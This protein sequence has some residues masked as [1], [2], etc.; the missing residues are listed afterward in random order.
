MSKKDIIRNIRSFAI[1]LLIH[2]IKQ[3][4]ENRTT[5]SWDTSIRNSVRDIQ[6]LNERPKSQ[7]YYLN[8]E[9]LREILIKAYPN[10]L[11]K[12]SLEVCEGIY[13]LRHLETIVN[14]TD[15]I[16]QALTLI[17]S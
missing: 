15:I 2:L 1:I 11:D 3:Q 7:G 17:V 8:S 16:E 9:E 10:A 4:V 13:E 14:Q 5:R 6:D 12:A